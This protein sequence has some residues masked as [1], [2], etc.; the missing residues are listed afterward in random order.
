MLLSICASI[1]LLFTVMGR[2]AANPGMKIKITDKGL[3]YARKIGV[4]LLE[5]KIKEFQLPDETGK[6][7]LMGWLDYKVS[8]LQLIDVGLPN[9]SAEF[10]PNIGIRFSTDVS[11]SLVGEL[12]VSLGLLYSAGTFNLNISMLSATFVVGFL[13]N[14]GRPTVK[15]ISCN[16]TLKDFEITFH[17]SSS[18][19]HR[20]FI[21]RT[22]GE[23]RKAFSK[24]VCSHF[25][26][27]IERLETMDQT[28]L[29]QV[30]HYVAFDY[31]LVREPVITANSI[32]WPIKGIVYDRQH[33]K[34]PP[35][36][37]QPFNL[38]DITDLMLYVGVS[39]DVLN[40]MGFAYFVAGALQID[41]TDDKTASVGAQVYISEMRLR[42]SVHLKSF[43]LVLKQSKVG[44][45]QVK[46]LDTI[47]TIVF[48]KNVL[49]KLN[50][51]LY[52]GKALLILHKVSLPNAIIKINKGMLMLGT[53]LEYRG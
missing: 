25:V 2:L 13:H 41:I 40:T 18:W 30:D 37:V 24:K 51:S 32:E 33:R 47:L 43:D 38:P 4:N 34:P 35:Y 22:K 53:D 26:S 28:A 10:I 17:G 46:A 3:Q 8:R 50:V 21:E 15:P 23:I 16:S 19:L 6:I 36:D 5:Q 48:K 1:V 27:L 52:R 49:P 44:N 45:I 12:E 39:E 42:G 31:S 9:S 29:Q 11:V 7:D 20:M 14:D